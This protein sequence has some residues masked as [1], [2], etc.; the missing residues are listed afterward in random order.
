MHGSS[1][2]VNPRRYIERE[3][4]NT[5]GVGPP[6]RLGRRA[7]WCTGEPIA[8]DTIHD[9]GDVPDAPDGVRPFDR[10]AH[11]LENVPLS[12]RRWRERLARCR[13]KHV[14]LSAPDVETEGRDHHAAAVV[15]TPGEHHSLPPHRTPV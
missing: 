6:D 4:W 3:H 13:E 11:P 14:H 1:R 8:D 10:H 15:L 2:G 5:L 12:G 9:E 7:A